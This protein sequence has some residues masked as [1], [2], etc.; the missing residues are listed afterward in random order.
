MTTY[1]FS[2]LLK[3]LIELLKYN[4][5]FTHIELYNIYNSIIN[6]TNEINGFSKWAEQIEIILND[7]FENI[8]KIHEI[9]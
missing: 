5:R 8:I 2:F 9:K 1:Q 6:K 4:K 3:A 7:W